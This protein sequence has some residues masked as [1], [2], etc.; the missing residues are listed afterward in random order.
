MEKHNPASSSHCNTDRNI[1]SQKSCCDDQQK[2]HET[3]DCDQKCSDQ[4]CHI[5]AKLNLSASSLLTFNPQLFD[6]SKSV[7]WK[8]D[9]SILCVSLSIWQPPR[10]V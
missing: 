4:I 8:N 3:N 2:H 5:P 6:I 7:F 10:L 9:M 1:R